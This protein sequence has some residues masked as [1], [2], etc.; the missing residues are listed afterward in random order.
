MPKGEPNKNTTGFFGIGNH[1]EDGVWIAGRSRF[2]NNDGCVYRIF[3]AV[4]DGRSQV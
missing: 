3:A 4:A 1:D 2:V